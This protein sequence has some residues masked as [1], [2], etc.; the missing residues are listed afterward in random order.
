MEAREEYIQQN[1]ECVGAAVPDRS[2][3][4]ISFRVLA[5]ESVKRVLDIVLSIIGLLLLSP[6]FLIVALAV[7]IDD[8][9]SPFY[10]Q[11]RVGR[12]GRQFLM[13]KFR[14]MIVTDKPLE[15][16][17]T[18]EEL[19]CYRKDFKLERDP[20]VTRVG[21][22][23]RRTSIDELPQLVNIIK[24]DL[25]IIGPRPVT[26]EETELYGADREIFLSVRPGLTGYWQAYARNSAGYDTGKRQEMELYYV[27]NRGFV[28]DIKVFFKTFEAVLRKTGV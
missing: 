10:V 8:G 20:R 6:V 27:K 18:K 17:L 4:L 3:L 28:L 14:S 25:S 21:R 23:I 22:F 11:R 7:F 15:E 13:Y 26:Q 5:Y 2:K 12:N 9:H 1:I 24:G 19:E 16:L